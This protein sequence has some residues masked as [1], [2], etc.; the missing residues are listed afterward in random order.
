MRLKRLKW[1]RLSF[2]TTFRG[3]FVLA[4]ETVQLLLG[5]DFSFTENI[6]NACIK[7]I[8]DFNRLAVLELTKCVKN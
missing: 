5:Y 6:E 2:C 4:I 1:T 7:S 3:R 8:Q